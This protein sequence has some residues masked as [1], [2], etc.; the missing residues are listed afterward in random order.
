MAHD[1]LKVGIIGFGAMGKMHADQIAYLDYVEIVSVVE[2]FPDNRIAAEKYFNNQGT[3]V[4]ED[5]TVALEASVLDGWIVTSS[6]KSHI[7]ITKQLL[8]YGASVLLEKPIGESLE[9]AKSLSNLL[10]KDP[11]KLMLGHILLWSKEFLAFKSVVEQAGSLYSMSCAR[12]RSAD[13]RVR[14]PGESPISLIMVHDLYMVHNLMAGK[15]PKK[16]SAQIRNHQLGG[17]DLALGQLGWENNEF[18]SFVAHFLVPEGLPEE[19]NA[20]QIS[21]WGD[22]WMAKMTFGKG[23]I[24][25]HSRGNSR[26]IAIDPPTRLGATNYFDDALRSEQECFFEVIKS[27]ASIP[28]GAT[29]EDACQIQGWVDTFN[30][31]TQDRG[32]V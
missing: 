27:K 25:F 20:D 6:T 9:S 26:V 10:K 22:D 18:A 4:Y 11:S 2:T 15:E 1:R 14:Y 16:F 13:H 30:S 17:M 19:V 7:A 23:E 21:A 24:E 32:A 3:V 28:L 8:E 31:L 29:Y 12:N 5:L